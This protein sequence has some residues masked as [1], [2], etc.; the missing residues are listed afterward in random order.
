MGFYLSSMAM[1][2]QTTGDPQII[3]R[4][5]YVLEELKTVQQTQGDGYLLATRRGRQAFTD[6]VAGRFET[7]NPMINDTWEPIYNE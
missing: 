3:D 7:S 5:R 1:M 4:L 2:Y 6:V